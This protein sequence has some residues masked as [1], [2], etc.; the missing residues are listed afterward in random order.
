[1]Q[2]S[3]PGYSVHGDSPG[4]EYYSGLP[5]LPPGNL[6]NPGI[7]PRS[8]GLQVAFLLAKLPGKP[9]LVPRMYDILF[10]KLQIDEK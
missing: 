9:W 2:C 10:Q 8:P 5:F 6:P 1:M 3:P 4:Q 7:E